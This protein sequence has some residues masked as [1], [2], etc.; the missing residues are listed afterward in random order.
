MGSSSSTRLPAPQGGP[1]AQQLELTPAQGVDP[2]PQEGPEGGRCA[3]TAAGGAGRS[4]PAKR[5]R[6]RPLKGISASR[7]GVAG[8]QPRVRPGRRRSVPEKIRAL[9]R[10]RLEQGQLAAAVGPQTPITSPGS[11]EREGPDPGVS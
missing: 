6:S 5:N 11:R 8:C 10:H 9:A 2:P 1:H 4:I 3:G 7:T